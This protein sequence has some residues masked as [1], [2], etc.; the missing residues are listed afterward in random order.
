MHHLAKRAVVCS[1]GW[2]RER[3]SIFLATNFLISS[4]QQ[5]NQTHRQYWSAVKWTRL[6]VVCTNIAHVCHMPYWAPLFAKC[7]LAL[8]NVANVTSAST[9]RLLSW[10]VSRDD[11]SHLSFWRTCLQLPVTENAVLQPHLLAGGYITYLTQQT[12][13]D[14]HFQLDFIG[15]QAPVQDYTYPARSGQ[16]TFFVTDTYLICLCS[17]IYPNR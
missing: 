6:N 2:E 1:D 8:L 15:L 12:T 14:F 3:V 11:D 17:S 5:T 9:R 16:H 7:Q 4:M 10:P 13:D